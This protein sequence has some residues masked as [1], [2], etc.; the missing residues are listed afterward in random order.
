ME[1]IQSLVVNP[2]GVNSPPP[3]PGLASKSLPHLELPSQSNPCYAINFTTSSPIM[4][5]D[6]Q[7]FLDTVS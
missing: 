7:A 1:R 4:S 3:A 6:D 2:V 5:A